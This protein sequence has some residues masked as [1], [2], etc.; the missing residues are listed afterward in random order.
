[1]RQEATHVSPAAGER[2]D[3]DHAVRQAASS[4]GGLGTANAPPL[5]GAHEKFTEDQM[6]ERFGVPPFGGIRSSKT[7]TDIILV[8]R[9]DVPTSYDDKDSG[10]YVYYDGYP[11][12]R[13]GQMSDWRNRALSESRR[14]A[15][16]VVFFVKEHGK[17][18]F[19]GRVECVGWEYKDDMARGRVAT[20]KLRSVSDAPAQTASLARYATAVNIVEDEDGW[21]VATAPALQGCISRGETRAKA[22]ENLEEAISLYLEHLLETGESF[23]PGLTAAFDVADINVRGESVSVKINTVSGC[24][25]T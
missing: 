16:R 24:K 6:G 9:V 3:S 14:N 12:E 23:P 8:S 5:P 4:H 19:H 17:L 20:F 25:Q 13:T 21:Y 11:E 15:S 7:S 10:E 22:R 18:A 2:H 1:M